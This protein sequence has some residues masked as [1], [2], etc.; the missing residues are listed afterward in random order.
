MKHPAETELALSAG[1]ELGPLARWSLRRHL[2]RCATCRAEVAAFV[3]ARES[4]AATANEL[5]AE[6]SWNRLAAD[7]KANIHVGL[8]AGECVGPERPV[9]VRIAWRATATVVPVAVMVLLGW[10]L[11]PSRPGV[12]RTPEAEGIVLEATTGGIELRE[13]GRSLALQ[14]RG[15]VD[16]TYSVNAQ[17]ALRARYVDSETGQVTINNVYVQ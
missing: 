10:W 14:H 13:H 16:V 4:L 7:M 11:L 6:V 15:N 9:R 2:A 17:G 12:T 8:A 1:D 3:V 5:P